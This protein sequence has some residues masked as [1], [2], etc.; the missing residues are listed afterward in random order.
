MFER[1][2][3]KFLPRN[4]ETPGK[5]LSLPEK[6]VIFSG[7]AAYF[8]DDSGIDNPI[9]DS[10]GN[11]FGAPIF[12]HYLVRKFNPNTTPEHRAAINVVLYS[13]AEIAQRVGLYPGTFDPKDFLAY[14]LGIGLA[15]TAEKLSER[16]QV[17]P[18][19]VIYN[20]EI[21]KENL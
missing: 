14:G 7:L 5:K 21:V 8:A 17:T 6:A 20:E 11:N 2:L 9:L 16:G 15:Y 4:N 3:R 1:E 13:T 18:Q 19:H 12:V 10:Y